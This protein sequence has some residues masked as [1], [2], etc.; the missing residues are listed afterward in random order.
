MPVTPEFLKQTKS[1][2]QKFTPEAL[3]L[4]DCRQATENAAGFFGVLAQWQAAV[5]NK[6]DRLS[7]DKSGI[8]A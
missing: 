7:Q 6:D 1:V 5:E 4:E 2:L 3:S 8:A